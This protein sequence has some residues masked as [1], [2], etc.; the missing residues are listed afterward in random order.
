MPSKLSLS[1]LLRSFAEEKK[2]RGKG[3]LC[4]ALVVTQRARE[5]LPLDPAK[6]MTPGVGQVAGLGKTQVQ[7]ILAKHS[8]DRVLAEEGGR[9]S[10]GSVGNMQ[11]YVAFLNRLLPPLDFDEIESFWIER[12]R[13]FFAGKPF[14]FRI[15]ASLSV[16]A[17]VRDLLQQARTRQSELPGSRYE[18]AMLQHLVGAKL[19]LVLPAGTIAH[20][21]A[22]EADQAEGRAGDFLVGDVAVHATTHPGEA[23]MRKCV[24]NIKAG[25]KP[26]I[27]T[28]PQQALVADALADA[29]QVLDQIDVL[30]IE[31]FLAANLHE[32]ALFQTKNRNA[33][34]EELLTIYNK[35]VEKHETDPSLKIEVAGSQPVRRRSRG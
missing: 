18:G 23:L 34:T 2:F 16:R 22:S 32:R 27:V 5:G 3:A 7:A 4:V 35:L 31:Q 15:D 30:D 19:E 29:A 6:L 20:H 26:L 12:V 13:E 17:A 10:R 33:R 8:I 25:L 1:A 24:D 14:K 28:V 9:T 11:A 21:S